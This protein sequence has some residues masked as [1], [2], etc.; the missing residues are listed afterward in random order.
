MFLAERVLRG[1]ADRSD[2]D[3]ALQELILAETSVAIFGTKRVAENARRLH[4][5]LAGNVVAVLDDPPESIEEALQSPLEGRQLL[6][7]AVE[8]IR[9]DLGQSAP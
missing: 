8:S 5:H 7:A 4:D 2:F 1:R 6:Q 3:E 9:T